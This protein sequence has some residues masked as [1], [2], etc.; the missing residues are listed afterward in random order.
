MLGRCD[1]CT[2]GGADPFRTWA[3]QRGRPPSHG[4]AGSHGLP[5]DDGGRENWDLD[6]ARHVAVAG[7]FAD[8]HVIPGAFVAAAGVAGA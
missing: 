1:G 4:C 6:D 5:G 8:A 7:L 3:E 2:R